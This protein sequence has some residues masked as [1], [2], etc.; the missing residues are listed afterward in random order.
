MSRPTKATL[1]KVRDAILAAV[2]H[3]SGCILT[4]PRRV[5]RTATNRGGVWRGIDVQWNLQ[6]F[7]DTRIARL[8]VEY[9]TSWPHERLM[10]AIQKRLPVGVAAESCQVARHERSE[11]C[12]CLH[13]IVEWFEERKAKRKL[14]TLYQRRADKNGAA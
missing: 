12:V 5:R 4:T 2:D 1:E 13:L 9:W 10:A 11:G 6:K 8:A 14:C 3:P 7:A